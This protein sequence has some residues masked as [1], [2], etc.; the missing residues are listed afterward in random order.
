MHVY[1]L[2]GMA[3]VSANDSKTLEPIA[4]HSTKGSRLTCLATI[5]AQPD[6]LEAIRNVKS[7][8]N[9]LEADSDSNSDSEEDQDRDSDEEDEEDSLESSLSDEDDLD[10]DELQAALEEVGR[11]SSEE[12]SDDEIKGAMDG[13]NIASDGAISAQV[14]EGED[15][16]EWTGIADE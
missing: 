14:S 2:E 6:A 10:S 9:G 4:K 11:T 15:D 5:I 7:Q 1:D 3:A 16:G 12:S 13:R 8:A